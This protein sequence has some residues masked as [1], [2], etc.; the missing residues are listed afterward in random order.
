MDKNKFQFI[1]D[2]LNYK[3]EKQKKAIVKLLFLSGA[4]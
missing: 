3:T 4:L 1:L 2:K